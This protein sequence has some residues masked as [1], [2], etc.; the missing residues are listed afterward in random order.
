MEK[1][2]IFG[3]CRSCGGPNI[4]LIKEDATSKLWECQDCSRQVCEYKIV[5]PDESKF[6]TGD[7]KDGSQIL[8]DKEE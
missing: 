6:A 2:D 8:Y 4:K 1:H 3:F 5:S 7:L